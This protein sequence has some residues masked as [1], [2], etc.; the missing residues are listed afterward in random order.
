MVEKIENIKLEDYE[1]STDIAANGI[2]D[3]ILALSD[4]FR[5][6]RRSY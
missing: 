3:R 5:K 2:S 1:D 6:H 4:Y